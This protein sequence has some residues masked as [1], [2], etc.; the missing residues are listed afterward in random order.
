MT[1]DNNE[2]SAFVVCGLYYNSTRRFSR[3]YSPSQASFAFGVNLWRG[4]VWG[5]RKD[6]GRRQLLKRVYN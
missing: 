2:Y 5:V 3:R 6:T 1:I 4:S